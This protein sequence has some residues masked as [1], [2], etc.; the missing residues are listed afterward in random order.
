MAV[1]RN[2]G[3]SEFDA[4]HEIGVRGTPLDAA[5]ADLDG[6]G[7]DDLVTADHY[8]QAPW[9]GSL[10]V[11]LGAGRRQSTD[12][13]RVTSSAAGGAA[14]GAGGGAT[15]GAAG[16][17][18]SDPSGVPRRPPRHLLRLCNPYRAGE[19]LEVRLAAA[20]PVR[21]TLY[22]VTGRRRRTLFTGTL[23]AGLQPLPWPVEGDPAGVC[24]LELLAG[25]Q[26]E[27]R[28]VTVV[29]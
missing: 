24:F 7:R 20:V 26:S 25:A 15:R 12:P 1:L 27:H 21:L 18:T 2:L 22:D 19:P 29:H 3:H 17:P 5:A 28:K 9:E 13:I 11:L 23:P 16:G 14:G 6:D 10:S 4:P 8:G